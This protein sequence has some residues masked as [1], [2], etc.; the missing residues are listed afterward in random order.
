MDLD[1]EVSKLKMLKASHMNALYDL[2]DNVNNVLPREIKYM[3]HNKELIEDD[4]QDYKARPVQLDDKGKPVFPSIELFGKVYTD[5]EEAGKALIEACRQAARADITRNV[6]VGSYQGF[7]LNIG[8]EPM[9]KVYVATLS[10]AATYK[11]ELGSSES[12][13]FTRLDNAIN[14]MEDKL[15]AA[16][17]QLER[18]NNQLEEA[19]AQ[20]DTPFPHEQ[21]L[22]EKSKR[23]DE[24][25]K[26]LE[27]AADD[28][29]TSELAEIVDPYYIEVSSEEAAEKLKNSGITFEMK[30]S[31]GHYIIK[32][33]R[34]DKDKVHD[35]LEQQKKIVL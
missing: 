29:P 4:I 2:Q 7:K 25:T 27:N 32:I 24:L 31:E 1:I 9:N 14:G 35:L 20:L 33:N 5:K 13:N 15:T 11:T 22:Q 23:L 10:G 26:Q 21:E 17:Q 19:M 16:K 28:K 12:G 6:E 18:L 3:E 8:Y 34:S 30:E